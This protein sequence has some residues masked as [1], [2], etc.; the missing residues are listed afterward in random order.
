MK[1][2]VFSLESV[3]RYKRQLLGVLK[4]E[5]ARL[6]ADLHEIENRIAKAENEFDVINGRLHS[7]LRGGL[8]AQDFASYKA[9]LHYL[10][11]NIEKLNTEKS[12]VLLKI[13]SKK[14]EIISMNSDISGLERLRDKHWDEYSKQS[15]KEQEL[16]I[17]EFIGRA[18]CA[19]E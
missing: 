10:N 5:M 14:Q 16:F 3:L 8:T 15:R 12:A 18:K 19:A 4:N 13:S 1:K 11:K 9:Y 6:E 17:E 7:A 2:F